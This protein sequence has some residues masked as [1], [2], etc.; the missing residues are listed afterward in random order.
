MAFAPNGMPARS[1]KPSL[2]LEVVAD[3]PA[4]LEAFARARAAV[5]IRAPILIQGETGAAK[6]VLARHAHRVSGRAG[7]FVAVNCG[8][9]PGELFEAG[10]I[11]SA[12]GG[13]LLLDEVRDLPLHLQAALLRFLDDGLVR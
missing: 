1:A 7:P 3:D 11:A 4:V 12:D 5:R 13:T 9:L 2:A 8:A 10:L 6:E